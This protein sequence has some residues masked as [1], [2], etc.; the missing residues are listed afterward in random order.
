M[1]RVRILHGPS[2]RL[3]EH[4]FV[5]RPIDFNALAD[6]KRRV[7]PVEHLRQPNAGLRLI[8]RTQLGRQDIQDRAIRTLTE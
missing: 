3:L 2:H 6:I 7:G 4:A 5:H 8:Q 1:K